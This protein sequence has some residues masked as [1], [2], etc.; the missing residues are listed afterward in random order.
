MI[1]RVLLLFTALLLV[2]CQTLWA[3]Q[4]KKIIYHSAFP[5]AYSIP[6]LFVAASRQPD[7]I[8]LPLLLTRDNVLVVYNDLVLQSATNVA[9][10]FPGRQRPDSNYYVIDFTL[11]EI[12]QL[13]YS[14]DNGEFGSITSHII[15]FA[16]G[17]QL[18]S[19][20]QTEFDYPLI[21]LP[22]IKYPW[23]HANEGVEISSAAL[24]SLIAH[25]D[26]ADATLYLKCFD[27]DELQRIKKDIIPGMPVEVNLIQGIDNGDRGETMRRGRDGWSNYSYDWLFT[28]IGLRFVS[29][30]ADG[31]WLDS[32]AGIKEETLARFIGDSQ[33]LKMAVYIHI[34][35][36]RAETFAAAAEKFLFTLNCDGLAVENPDIL[37]RLLKNRSMDST[38]GFSKKKNND[39]DAILSD[40]EALIERLKHVQ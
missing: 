11:A 7:F 34:R 28:R 26:S 30:Y 38:S 40:P 9:D 5:S 21:A 2:T 17:L 15:T 10:I 23:F 29:G 3:D 32:T 25:T 33:G 31:I 22:V 16:D 1:N 37:R 8:E 27:P 12:Q 24:D 39:N 18:L 13:T 6:S 14:K 36:Q 35:D 19:V 20:L 4:S